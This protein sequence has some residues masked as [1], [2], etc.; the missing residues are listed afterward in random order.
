[1]TESDSWDYLSVEQ[2]RASRMVSAQQGT[3]C[4]Y[5]LLLSERGEVIGH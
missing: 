4:D 2:R 3:E 1:M 5:R